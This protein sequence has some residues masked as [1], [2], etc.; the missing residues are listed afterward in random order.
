METGVSFMNETMLQVKRLSEDLKA[1]NR[2]MIR[3]LDEITGDTN[4]TK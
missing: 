1:H 3:N 4:K 2:E